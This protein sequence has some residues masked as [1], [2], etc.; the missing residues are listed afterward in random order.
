MERD[1]PSPDSISSAI[2]VQCD[3]AVVLLL[4]WAN[5]PVDSADYHNLVMQLHSTFEETFRFPTTTIYLETGKSLELQVL[6]SV[7]GF[8][9]AHDGQG[10]LLIVYYAGYV[11]VGDCCYKKELNKFKSR[12]EIVWVE[13]EKVLRMATAHVL[14]IFDGFV[15]ANCPPS[16]TR[17]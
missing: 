10:D 5:S 17:H 2:Q 1:T 11:D 16:K 15:L 3:K 12:D 7:S 13:C 8:A 4:C 9:V 6:S 14:W